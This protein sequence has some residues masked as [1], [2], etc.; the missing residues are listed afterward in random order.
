MASLCP[1]LTTREL[2]GPFRNPTVGSLTPGLQTHPSLLT[3]LKIHPNPFPGGI[4]KS[5]RWPPYPLTSSSNRHR[6]P[7]AR[8]FWLGSGTL[9]LEGIPVPP[10]FSKGWLRSAPHRNTWCASFVTPCSFSQ[11]IFQSKLCATFS[12]TRNPGAEGSR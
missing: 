11:Q 10:L 2:Q 1:L 6:P 5:A 9:Y 3:A 4:N 8:A 12:G 7:A